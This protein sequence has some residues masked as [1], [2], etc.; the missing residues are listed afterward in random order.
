MVAMNLKSGSASGLCRR[1]TKCYGTLDSNIGSVAVQGLVDE[2]ISVVHCFEPNPKILKLLKLN[3]S[4]NEG[5]YCVH[6]I[7]L[8]NETG[9]AKLHLGLHSDAVTSSLAWDAGKGDILVQCSTIDDV[10]AFEPGSSTN[11]DED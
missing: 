11:T 1:A 5:S 9:S 10:I 2:R 7:A 3:L 6:E 4:L 8:S